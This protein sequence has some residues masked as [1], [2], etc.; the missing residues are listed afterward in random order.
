MLVFRFLRSLW[1]PFAG[2]SPASSTASTSTD[3]T[4]RGFLGGLSALVAAPLF[5]DPLRPSTQTEDLILV[6]KARPST[7]ADLVRAGGGMR[8]FDGYIGV[9][10]GIVLYLAPARE[11]IDFHPR[12]NY[13]QHARRQN[14]VISGRT[15][16]VSAHPSTA[17]EP[18]AGAPDIF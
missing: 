15:G 16:E 2:S 9:Y 12:E 1:E 18:G 5:V 3:L 8:T 7:F 10:R 14:L 6:F 17:G 13:H 11:R 4:R